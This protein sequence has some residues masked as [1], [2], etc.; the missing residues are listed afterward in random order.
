MSASPN[1]L[2][3]RRSRRITTAGVVVFITTAL[4][5]LTAPSIH[6]AGVPTANAGAALTTA[7]QGT[8]AGS[9]ASGRYH[10]CAVRGDGGITCWGDNSVGQL[11]APVGTYTAVA[12]G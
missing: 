8:V 4:A 10:S 12:A 1:N 5:L 11:N 6:A 9:I 7:A 3:G 2:D